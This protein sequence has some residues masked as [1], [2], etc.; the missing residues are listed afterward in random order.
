M[1]GYTTTPSFRRRC[2]LR[3]HELW[4][5]L[6]DRLRAALPKALAVLEQGIEAN[7][8]RAAL[9]IIKAAGPATVAPVGL[10]DP[11]EIQ[12]INQE[13]EQRREERAML[14]ALL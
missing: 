13:R 4:T 8:L 14:T 11:K 7:D 10:T 5:G 6:S 12:L 2:N 9:A 3:R 1:S